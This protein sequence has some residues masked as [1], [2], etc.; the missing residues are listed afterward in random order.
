MRATCVAL[1]CASAV[2]AMAEAPFLQLPLTCDYGSTC[3]IEDYVDAD[4][5]DAQHDF[6]CGL[7]SRQGHRGTDFSLMSD[8]QLADDVD[9]LAAADGIVQAT[10]NGVPDQPYTASLAP[11]LRGKECGNAVRIRHNNGFDTLYCHLKNGSLTV[12]KGDQVSAGTPLGH[13]GMS[14]Q[15]NFAHLHFTVLKDGKVVDP[16]APTPSD[17]CGANSENS[18]WLVDLPYA[19]TGLFTASFTIWTPRMAHVQS[20]AAR[21]SEAKTTDNLLLYGYA[22]H[23]Q[24]GDQMAFEAIGPNGRVF[25]DT[26]TIEKGQAQ[27][28]RAFG[29]KAPQA[30]WDAGDYAGTVKLLRDGQVLAIRNAQIRIE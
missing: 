5:T 27:L 10:R 24:T 13:I 9:V 19:E 4:P 30:G 3:V 22:F 1:I 25:A 17:T 14:G 16:F 20:G 26:V 18:L 29:R 11:Q 28:F 21:R 2:P 12:Q 8:A 6:A 23:A 7:K 15:S